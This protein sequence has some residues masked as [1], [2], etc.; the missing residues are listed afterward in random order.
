MNASIRALTAIGLILAFRS[1]PFPPSALPRTRQDTRWRI[2]ASRI[3]RKQGR[4]RARDP[5]FP[6]HGNLKPMA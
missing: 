5:M 2:I 1:L 4:S 6:L 3:S